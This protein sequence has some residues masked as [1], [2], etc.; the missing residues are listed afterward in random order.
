[1]VNHH[2]T[3]KSDRRVSQKPASR[4][5]DVGEYLLVEAELPSA[6]LQNIGVLLLD[7]K[8]DQLYFRFR[9]DFEEIAGEDAD[10][11]REL[12]EY[13]LHM[14]K[15]LGGQQCIEW[16]EST[17][18]NS[19][20]ISERKRVRIER[21][22][23]ATVDAL[24]AKHIRPKVL[25]FRTHL[26]QYSLEAA[27][28]KFGRQMNVDPEG[29]VEVRTDLPLTK[30]MFV[31]HVEGHSMEPTI[32]DGSLCAFRSVI[33]GSWQG[34]VLLLEDYGESG[35]SRHTVKLCHLSKSI[36]PNGRGDVAWLHHRMTLESTN[37]AYESWDVASAE[38]IRPLGEF[39][40]VVS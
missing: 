9:R 5:V 21:S 7:T 23:I 38:K 3:D 34:K 1:V 16:L 33:S 11:F 28:G 39:L 19:L 37:P 20:R 40:F 17:L 35:G 15:K 36:D 13:I 24:Y 18:S 6:S 4:K 26:P 30:D 2:N 31:V 29:W 8:S 22:A 32:P 27:A 25:R 10:W 12:P 14:G